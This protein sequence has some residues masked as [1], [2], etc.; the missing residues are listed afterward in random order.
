MPMIPRTSSSIPVH[1][2]TL[3]VT[4]AISNFTMSFVDPDQRMFLQRQVQTLWL[5][6]FARKPHVIF[7][8]HLLL[9]MQK[10]P[11][12]LNIIFPHSLP[13]K[14][15]ARRVHWIR[16]RIWTIGHSVINCFLHAS[17]RIAGFAL[18]MSWQQHCTYRITRSCA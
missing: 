5:E 16:L 10:M 13:L 8:K 9:N 6:L 15:V 18:L 14:L 7:L 17:G 2:L 1:L 11:S 4:S 12:S 3:T